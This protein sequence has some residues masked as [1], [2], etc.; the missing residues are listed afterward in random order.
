M[1]LLLGVYY[2]LRNLTT[3]F[4]CC[5]LGY[6]DPQSANQGHLSDLPHAFGRRSRFSMCDQQCECLIYRSDP[7]LHVVKVATLPRVLLHDQHARTNAE[8]PHMDSVVFDILC[9]TGKQNPGRVIRPCMVQMPGQI[10]DDIL[11]YCVLRRT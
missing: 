10:E 4:Y 3:S 8:V 9:T 6:V 2:N 11:R 7:A 5:R 1:I